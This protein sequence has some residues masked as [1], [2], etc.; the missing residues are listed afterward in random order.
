MFGVVYSD[1]LSHLIIRTDALLRSRPEVFA[2]TV[3]VSNRKSAASKRAVVFTMS[4]GGGVGDTVK[5]SYAT[6]DVIA[7]DEGDAADLMNL[8]LALATSRGAGGMVDGQPLLAA[9]INGGPNSDPA[10]DG[11]FKQTAELELQHRGVNL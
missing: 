3:E 5:T 10:A 11:F 6:V 7:N 8:V 4:P 1:V 2:R 9:T